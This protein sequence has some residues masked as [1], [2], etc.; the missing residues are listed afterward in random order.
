MANQLLD[1]VWTKL[2][3][4]N[5]A[6][7]LNELN[8]LSVEAFKTSGFGFQLQDGMD[9]GLCKITS[10][11]SKIQF[12]G[13]HLNLICVQQNRLNEIIGDKLNIGSDS[14][15]KF[16]NHELLINQGDIIYCPPS[17]WHQVAANSPRCGIS[18]GFGSLAV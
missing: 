6:F 18:M 10:D 16:T 4:E 12:A 17:R 5:P 3:G 15:I 1:K 9:I 14:V 8:A 2:E 7:I 11:S 13:A